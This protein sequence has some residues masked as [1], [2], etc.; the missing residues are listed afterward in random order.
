VTPPITKELRMIA[1]DIGVRLNSLKSDVTLAN[2]QEVQK[3][4]DKIDFDYLQK[5]IGHQVKLVDK[6]RQLDTL[7]DNSA[8]VKTSLMGVMNDLHTLAGDLIRLI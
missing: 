3:F 6:C 2:L 1:I 8:S 4:P 5:I 7:G